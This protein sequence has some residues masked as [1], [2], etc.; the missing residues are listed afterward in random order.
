M[1]EV[2]RVARIEGYTFG[3]VV[4]DGEEHR[5]DVIVL[6]RRVVGNWWRRE[7]HSMDLEDLADVMEELPETLVVGTGA[8]GQMRPTDETIRALEDRG[9][10]VEVLRTD[11]AVRRFT[12][13]D[14]ERAAAALHLTC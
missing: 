8:D 1:K 4:V 13:L 5:K 11:R 6:P 2:P 9:V 12:E 10:Q 7:G 3:H 14:P